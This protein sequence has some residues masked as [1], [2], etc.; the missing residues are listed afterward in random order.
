MLPPIVG[1]IGS[2]EFRSVNFIEEFVTSLTERTIVVSGGARGVDT[3]AEIAAK[4][5]HLPFKKFS[6]EPFEWEISTNK[7]FPADIRNELLVQ[8]IQR[9]LGHKEK[10]TIFAF[11]SIDPR[12][13]MLSTGAGNCLGHAQR[14]GVHWVAYMEYKG[15]IVKE[16]NSHEPEKFTDGF[17]NLI[18]KRKDQLQI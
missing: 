16:F 18:V 15:K 2:R 14:L 4:K 13:K 1:I 6:I 9:S 10:G 3:I 8:Y 17:R 7:F 5:A 12:T 11:W